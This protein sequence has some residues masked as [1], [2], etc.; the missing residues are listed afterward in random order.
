MSELLAE[1]AMRKLSCSSTDFFSSISRSSNEINCEGELGIALPAL[2]LDLDT[3]DFL[4]TSVIGIEVTLACL[5]V[6]V[7]AAEVLRGGLVALLLA[8]VL[9]FASFFLAIALFKLCIGTDDPKPTT[10]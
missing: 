8:T 5:D 9:V 6:V 7:V 1:W 2:S 10:F 3:F 4:L